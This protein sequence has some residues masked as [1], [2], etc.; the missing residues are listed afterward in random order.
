MKRIYFIAAAL[1][2]MVSCQHDIV[3]S[4]DFTVTLDESNTYY[5]GDPVRFNFT[6]EV[7]NVIFY[8]GETGHQYKYKD[9]Y[10]VPIEDIISIRLDLN[11]QARYGLADALEIWVTNSFDGLKGDDGVA[12]RA[13]IKAMVDG[14]MSGW[15]KLNWTDGASTKW[16]DQSYGEAEGDPNF[17]EMSDN[18]CIAFHWCPPAYNQTQ[19][20]YWVN[21]NLHLE[22]SGLDPS[23]T[24]LSQLGFTTV[25]MNEQIEDPYKKNSGN[26]SIILNNPATAALIFQGVG[27]NALDYTLDGW[28]ISTPMPLNKVANDKAVVIK[29][30]QNYMHSYEY[31]FEEPG[32]YEVVLVGS[33]ESYLQKDGSEVRMKINVLEK[34]N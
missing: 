2:V 27:G 4:S 31:V 15:T 18:F 3:R 24:E 10:T 13:T 1:L 28:A 22:L 12:D 16:K 32:T 33:I 7:D 14:G 21:G 6:G 8:S 5:A 29:N 9:R 19:R 26:G 11:I 34:I 20:T 30:V 17:G 25:M 23:D